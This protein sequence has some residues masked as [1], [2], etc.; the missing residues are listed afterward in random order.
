MICSGRNYNLIAAELISDSSSLDGSS[1]LGL[2]QNEDF[3]IFSFLGQ[4][5]LNYELSEFF[6]ALLG[7]H[8]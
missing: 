5:R 3:Q 4:Q 7:W 2:Q 1:R 6:P 8:N